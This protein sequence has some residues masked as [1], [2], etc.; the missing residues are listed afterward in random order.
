MG[1]HKN[2]D[3]TQLAPSAASDDVEK[4]QCF[5]LFAALG[6]EASEI[7]ERTG[8]PANRIRQ[9]ML[10][11]KWR[12]QKEMMENHK[13]NSRPAIEQPI[14]KAVINSRKGELREKFVANTGEMAAEDSEHWKQLSPEE[15]IVV[16]P[17]I[18]SLNGVHRKNLSLDAEEENKERGHIV[19]SFLNRANE[20]GMVKP[21]SPEKI[22]EIEQ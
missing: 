15:R 8:I 6:M 17:A 18:A 13:K 14:V 11:E 20:P 1:K 7:E 4:Q 5:L 22:K 12:D 19:L 10:R 3:P 2:T 21:I 9:W 16:A